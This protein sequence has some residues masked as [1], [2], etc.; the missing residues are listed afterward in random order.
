MRTGRFLQRKLNRY[1]D[2]ILSLAQFGDDEFI[3]NLLSESQADSPSRHLLR[4][5]LESCPE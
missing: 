3:S 2:R 5:P 1:H 4:C